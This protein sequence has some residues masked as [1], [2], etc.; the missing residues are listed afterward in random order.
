MSDIRHGINPTQADT[1]AQFPPGTIA[2]DPRGGVFGGNRI[3]YV[4]AQSALTA[5]FAVHIDVG[6]TDDPFAVNPTSAINQAVE[7]V[8]HSAIPIGNFGWITIQGNVPLANVDAAVTA[9]VNLVS[10]AS[11]GRLFAIS[12]ADALNASN[13]GRTIKAMDAAAAN[14]AKVY[15][16]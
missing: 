3:R 16:Y 9:G 11:A 2:D 15:I 14:V 6:Q 10:G 4:R 5:N 12:T 7:G 13:Q 1:T 8:A